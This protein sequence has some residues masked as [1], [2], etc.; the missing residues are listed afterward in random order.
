MCNKPQEKKSVYYHGEDVC[1]GQFII[2]KIANKD[3][4][5]EICHLMFHFIILEINILEQVL[6]RKI[7][8]G[9]LY[10]LMSLFYYK[11]RSHKSFPCFQMRMNEKIFVL[12]FYVGLRIWQFNQSGRTSNFCNQTITHYVTQTINSHSTF[13]KRAVTFKLSYLCVNL[14]MKPN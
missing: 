5:C 9:E 12:I 8:V 11:I 1:L 7:E 2:L 13:K 10:L 4:K 6:I 14:V 3:T